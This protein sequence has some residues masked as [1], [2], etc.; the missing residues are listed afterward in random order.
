MDETANCDFRCGGICPGLLQTRK[1]LQAPFG[2]K[3]KFTLL[4]TPVVL[5]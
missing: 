1:S 3:S 2:R 5:I 4:T